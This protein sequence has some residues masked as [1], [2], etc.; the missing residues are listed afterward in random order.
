MMPS[1]HTHLQATNSDPS[2]MT[3]NEGKP[4]VI[5][6]PCRKSFSEKGLNFTRFGGKFYEIDKCKYD[7]G[8]KTVKFLGAYVILSP[9]AYFV[10]CIFDIYTAYV[11]LK[12]VE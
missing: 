6:L 1:R 5:F 3:S 12:I 4:Y 2:S 8:W 10:F 7:L 11:R 9:I